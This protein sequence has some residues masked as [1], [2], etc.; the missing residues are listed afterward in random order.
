[1]SVNDVVHPCF[2]ADGAGEFDTCVPCVSSDRVLDR[3]R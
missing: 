1:M 3:W 2:R